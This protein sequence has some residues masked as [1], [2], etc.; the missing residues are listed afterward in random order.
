MNEDARKVFN[1]A[2]DVFLGHCSMFQYPESED[3]LY[4]LIDVCFNLEICPVCSP[5]IIHQYIQLVL[6]E[7]KAGQ[8]IPV[9]A[10]DLTGIYTLVASVDSPVARR[11]MELYGNI[12]GVTLPK[13]DSDLGDMLGGI[14]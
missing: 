11:L 1:E 14:N 2:L 9:A 7:T 6:T 4:S 13:P 10:V 12:Q 3:Y 5:Q 8:M